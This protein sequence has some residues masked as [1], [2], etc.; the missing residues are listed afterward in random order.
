[1][2]YGPSYRIFSR[3]WHLLDITLVFVSQVRGGY[4]DHESFTRRTR[5]CVII[6]EQKITLIAIRQTYRY[7]IERWLI[8][9]IG[10]RASDSF[11]DDKF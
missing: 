1:M 5:R 7:V 9:A 2:S 4:V 8:I 11:R 6:N 10:S 3:S